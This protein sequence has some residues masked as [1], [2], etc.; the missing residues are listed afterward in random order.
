VNFGPHFW[1]PPPGF[2]DQD[3]EVDMIGSDQ[4]T[5]SKLQK[6]RAVGERYDEQIVEDIVYDIVDEVDFW[7]QDGGVS[8]KGATNGMRASAG[9]SVQDGMLA[10]GVLGSEEIKEL[11][12]DDE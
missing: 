3:D 4:P 8:G 6:L 1:Y 10:G 9:V 2:E 11:V 12:Q 7:M 5:T